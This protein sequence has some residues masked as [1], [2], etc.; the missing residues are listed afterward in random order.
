MDKRIDVHIDLSLTSYCDQITL[1]YI[2]LGVCSIDFA[3]CQ[4]C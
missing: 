1:K 3:I 4:G 2:T